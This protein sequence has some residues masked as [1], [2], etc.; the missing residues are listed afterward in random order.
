MCKLDMSQEYTTR[1]GRVSRPPNW[2]E[3][4]RPR[5]T[6]SQATTLR[7]SESA[8]PSDKTIYGYPVLIWGR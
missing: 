7:S 3:G 6:L 5:A 4:T 2:Y 8:E 1:S